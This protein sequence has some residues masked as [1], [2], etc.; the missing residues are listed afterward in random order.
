M[1][2]NLIILKYYWPVLI[3]TSADV[4]QTRSLLSVFEEDALNLT[5]YTNKLLQ[6]M[7]R[8]YGAQVLEL[9]WS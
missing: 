2:K 7:Q 6:S 8:V 5:D 1:F 3:L 4:S 9:D